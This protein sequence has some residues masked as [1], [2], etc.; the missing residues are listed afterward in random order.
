M[1]SLVIADT[2]KP[3]LHTTSALT[4][5]STDGVC[6]YTFNGV[7]SGCIDKIGTG[8]H[9]TLA[10]DVS[11]SVSDVKAQVAEYRTAHADNTTNTTSTKL[12]TTSTKNTES[13]PFTH[14]KSAWNQPGTATCFGDTLTTLPTTTKPPAITNVVYPGFCT[15]NDLRSDLVT[16]SDDRYIVS[17]PSEPDSDRSENSTE[18][19]G[20]DVHGAVFIDTP[21]DLSSTASRALLRERMSS[22]AAGNYCEIEGIGGEEGLRILGMA[23]TS[24]FNVHEDEEALGEYCV[25]LCVL[26]VCVRGYFVIVVDV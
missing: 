21:F 4:S 19:D 26:C 8:M 13:D 10:G 7:G 11:A 16:I 24:A 18:S 25:Y 23:S 1:P 15:S 12:T 9:G 22:G 14:A 5:V 3:L 20:E 6:L 17:G 2:D